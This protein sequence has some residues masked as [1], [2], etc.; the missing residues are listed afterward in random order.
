MRFIK[1]NKEKLL[2]LVPVGILL[3]GCMIENYESVKQQGDVHIDNN[4]IVTDDSGN[5]GYIFDVGEHRITVSR[6][7]AFYHK[8]S[9]VEG[10]QIESVEVKGWR[11]NNKV[12]YVNTVPVI[13]NVTK[14][15]K[16]GQYYFDEFGVPTDDKEKIL[17]K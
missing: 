4:S 5:I 16:D 14:V 9:N 1:F 15:G 11:D 8:I 3:A 2:V 13:V 17:Q 10:Y 7:D 6:N 12:T